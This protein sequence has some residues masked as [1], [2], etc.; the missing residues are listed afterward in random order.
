MTIK[1]IQ[2]LHYELATPTIFSFLRA[3][4]FLALHGDLLI[5]FSLH[6]KVGDLDLAKP[7]KGVIIPVFH[8]KKQTEEA[9]Q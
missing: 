6:I 8:W 4:A 2:I 9:E 7:V 1:R 3:L 5:P